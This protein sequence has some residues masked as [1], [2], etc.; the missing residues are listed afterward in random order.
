MTESVGNRVEVALLGFQPPPVVEA[1]E[2]DF[3]VHPVY[4][5]PDPA[6]ALHE[7]GGRIRGAAAHGMAG[8]TRS[9]IELMP[10]LEICA[11]NGVGLETSDLALCRERGIVLTVA[12]V[13]YDDVRDL[14]LT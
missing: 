3:I 1:L 7:V 9:Q 6:A 12:S 11:I 13:P 2:R 4:S 8:L 14:S 5:A 10:R